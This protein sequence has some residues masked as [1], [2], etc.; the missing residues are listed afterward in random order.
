MYDVRLTP[1]VLGLQML[2][3]S[4]RYAIMM[5]A[6]LLCLAVTAA[7]WQTNALAW[8]HAQAFMIVVALAAGVWLG[9][10]ARPAQSAANPVLATTEFIGPQPSSSPTACP[11]G[12][13]ELSPRELQVLDLLSNGLTNAQIA[14]QLFVS[15]NTV[16]T[17][18][19]NIYSK[20]GLSNRA[21]AV[22]YATRNLHSGAT[23]D[24]ETAS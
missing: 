11:P 23:N 22:R 18:V 19:A 8:Q 12:P 9:R 6:V 17:H 20:L 5:V 4:F 7:L 2:L 13:N 3:L 15:A 1:N 24:R 21:Q 16:K 10:Q 14:N